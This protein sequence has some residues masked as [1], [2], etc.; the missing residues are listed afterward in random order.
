MKEFLKEF[1]AFALKGNVVDLAVGVII[2]AAFKD[3]INSLVSDIIT[4]LVSGIA[5][6]F[7]QG[8]LAAVNASRFVLKIGSEQISYGNF[9]SAVLNFFF[10]ALIIFL[11]V[12]AIGKLKAL[13]PAG[14]E[15]LLQPDVR[16]CP[17]CIS[18]ISDQATRCPHCT[19][20]L[21]DQA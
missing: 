21:N 4:P 18:E 16:K 20:A 8:D 15:E 19:S 6:L 17:Y 3:I 7:V 12:K 14:Q 2:G 9:L 13:S 5:S 10:M 1:K 11:L